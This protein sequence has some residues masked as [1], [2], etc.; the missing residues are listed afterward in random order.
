M[1]GAVR[2]GDNISGSFNTG[3]D[4]DHNGHYDLEGNPV[5]PTGTINGTIVSGGSPNVFI[6]GLPAALDG[7]TT[8]EPDV[9]CSASGLLKHGAVVGSSKVFIN[10]KRAVII[11]DVVNTHVTPSEVVVTGGSGNVIFG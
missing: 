3:P 1:A 2:I 6:N 4:Y 10:G 7:S 8:D 5:H 9:C 11:G